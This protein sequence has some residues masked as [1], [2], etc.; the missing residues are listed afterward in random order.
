MTITFKRSNRK[1]TGGLLKS[2]RKK[3]KRDFGSDFIP[4]RIGDERKKTIEGLANLKKQRLLQA[5]F[6]NVTDPKT[7]K[8]QRTKIL[9]VLEH[10]DNINYTRMNIVTKGCVVKTETGK[11]KVTSKPGQ[12]GVV[13]GILI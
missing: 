4:V 7:G 10:M 13:N 2:Q 3:K 6:I 5:N 12:H 8:T 1:F 9:G 11:A